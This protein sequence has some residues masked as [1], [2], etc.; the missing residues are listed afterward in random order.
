MT[1]VIANEREVM[2]YQQ[3]HER[4]LAREVH[5]RRM[6]AGVHRQSWW[7]RVRSWLGRIYE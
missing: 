7:S 3:Y 5:L 4:S 1:I 6:F 2:N